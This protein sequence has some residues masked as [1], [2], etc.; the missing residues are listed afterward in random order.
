MACSSKLEQAFYVFR[1]H[2]LKDRFDCFKLLL[3]IVC[4]DD[5]GCICV[6]CFAE[7]L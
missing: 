7:V 6:F 3:A 5:F 2:V 4:L 1:G